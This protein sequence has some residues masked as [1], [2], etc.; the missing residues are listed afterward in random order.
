MPQ[1]NSLLP[2]HQLERPSVSEE[3][4]GGPALGPR[5]AVQVGGL[6]IHGPIARV[7]AYVPDC[8]GLAGHRA[9]HAYFLEEGRRDEVY[10]LARHREQPSGV[11]GSNVAIP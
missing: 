3:I 8:R 5:L 11:T 9:R 2:Q 1:S 6:D 10:V 7:E 4:V